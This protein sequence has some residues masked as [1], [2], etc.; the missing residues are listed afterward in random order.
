M[1]GSES[2][3]ALV[4]IG[5]A[6]MSC[7]NAFRACETFSRTS[8]AAFSRSTFNSNSTVIL[9]VPCALEE[10][11]FRTPCT[12]FTAFSNGSVICCSMI[13]ALAPVYDVR[14]FITAGSIAGYS[15]TPRKV[16]P[17]PPKIIMT[18]EQTMA[19][20]GRF[21]L[22]SDKF[23]DQELLLIYFGQFHSCPGPQKKQ[24]RRNNR[25]A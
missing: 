18:M 5:G 15:L 14:T 1:I 3:S 2:A 24:A 10:V 4:T 8:L 17:I 20:T 6:S 7:G 19:N 12:P 21:K 25:I 11:I 9:L 22:S 13:S 23:I 16:K